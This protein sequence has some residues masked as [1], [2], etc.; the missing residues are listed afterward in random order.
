MQPQELYALLQGQQQG[1]DGD[2]S[3]SGSSI[4][5]TSGLDHQDALQFAGG[6][7]SSSSSSPDAPDAVQHRI[8]QLGLEMAVLTTFVRLLELKMIQMEGDEGT[9]VG[10]Q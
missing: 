9:G 7:S 4:S 1:Q 3:D 8:E 6:S 2:G 10:C 5:S